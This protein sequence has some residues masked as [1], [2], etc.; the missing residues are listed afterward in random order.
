[1]F[2]KNNKAD[3]WTI[4][5]SRREPPSTC[6]HI[7]PPRSSDHHASRLG[8]TAFVAP[9]GH[10]IC[11][12]CESGAS[13]GTVSNISFVSVLCLLGCWGPFGGLSGLLGPS[14]GFAGDLG[15]LQGAKNST[16][17]FA[18]PLFVGLF[19]G[20]HGALLGYLGAR[21]VLAPSWADLGPF[22]GALQ[23]FW[24]YLGG[25]LGPPWSARNQKTRE[26]K[27]PSRFSPTSL[28]MASWAPSWKAA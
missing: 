4:L 10:A 8:G 2:G 20:H 18:T 27:N 11:L 12:L 26:R 24:S 22:G 19:W 25:L 3:E 6:S 13:D 14:W 1:M 17:Q 21:A 16:C 9:L 7:V 15:G 5:R 23:P 28:V